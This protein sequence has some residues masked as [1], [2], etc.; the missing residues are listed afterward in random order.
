L[1]R[2]TTTSADPSPTMNPS[3]IDAGT[4][5]RD[6]A[7]FVAGFLV[8]L[9][10][11]RGEI[12]DLVQEIFLVA[13]RRGGY[14]QGAARPTTWLA[15]IAV[16][17]LSTARRTKRRRPEEPDDDALA[18]LC[19]PGDD[20]ERRAD[21]TQMLARVQRALEAIPIERRAIFV[22]FEIEG[23]ACD[24]IAAGLGIPV[25]TIYSRLHTAR[26]EFAE[27]YERLERT[28]PRSVATTLTSMVRP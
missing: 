16:R 1:E 13:H 8:R 27:A 12:D 2:P 3:A 28:A 18:L 17:V 23:E 9:G 21:T 15:E 7:A 11:A 19:T 25:K 4:L 20:P 26:K 22:L 5:F 14:V 24:A 6:H 10:A